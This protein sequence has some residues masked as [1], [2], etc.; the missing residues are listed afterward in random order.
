MPKR[1]WVN[2]GW[3]WYDCVFVT[4]NGYVSDIK[5]SLYLSVCLSSY[6]SIYL[7]IYLFFIYPCIYIYTYIYIYICTYIFTYMIHNLYIYIYTYL[8]VVNRVFWVQPVLGRSAVML[9]FFTRN[10][11]KELLVSSI[12]EHCPLIGS[13]AFK[14]GDFS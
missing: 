10:G 2:L 1:K 13:L 6:L 3:D 5:L 7:P 4:I 11:K 9:Y 8:G 12:L 14:N